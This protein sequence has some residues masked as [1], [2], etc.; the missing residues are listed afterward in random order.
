MQPTAIMCRAQQ[1]RQLTL[2]AN[3]VLPNVRA[4]ATTAAAAWAK[5]AL[6]ADKRDKRAAV[7]QQGATDAAKAL[8]LVAHKDRGLSENPDR[9][10]ADVGNIEV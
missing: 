7:R 6:D 4:I 3:A 5:E 1:A 8:E 9:G 2:A 10:F